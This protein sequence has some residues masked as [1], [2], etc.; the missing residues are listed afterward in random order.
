MTKPKTKQKA[1][2]PPQTARKDRQ[3]RFTQAIDASIV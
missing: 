3:A 1:A 2:N